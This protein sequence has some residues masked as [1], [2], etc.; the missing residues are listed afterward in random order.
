MRLALATRYAITVTVA[1]HRAF[2]FA[3]AIHIADETRTFCRF[4]IHNDVTDVEGV[5]GPLFFS[6]LFV[7]TV[8]FRPVRQLQNISPVTSKIG[9]CTG[10]ATAMIKAAECRITDAGATHG[11]FNLHLATVAV[12]HR[13]YGVV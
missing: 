6:A 10:V 1:L 4:P 9:G 8:G 11:I 2:D 3:V 12:V 5:D 7:Q 13:Q